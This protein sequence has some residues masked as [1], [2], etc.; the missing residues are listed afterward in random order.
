MG[1]LHLSPTEIIADKPFT[2]LSFT[3]QD[4][5]AIRYMALCVWLTL[6]HQMDES[7]EPVLIHQPSAK[8]WS[9]RIVI[10]Q[11]RR[12]KA[13]RPLTVVGFFGIRNHAANLS[14]AQELDR[15]LIPELSN[16]DELLGYVS[17]C[18]PTGNFG[19]LVLFASPR[20]K[21]QW[22]ESAKHAEAVRMLTPDFYAAI[23]LYNGELPNGVADPE[24]LR[25][26]LVKYYDYG[27]RPLWRAV[28][29]LDTGGEG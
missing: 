21:E 9:Q 29:P 7:T 19:N 26:I 18:L 14:L 2:D 5:P 20:G 15:Q 11:P 6:E 25:L 24:S 22:G 4:S 3:R 1:P 16:Y 12:L 8:K 28:R 13:C 17:L 27:E 23:R 10:T